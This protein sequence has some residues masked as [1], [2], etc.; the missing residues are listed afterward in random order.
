MGG[1]DAR[2]IEWMGG[3]KVTR[4]DKQTICVLCICR[5]SFAVIKLIQ[6][7]RLTTYIQGWISVDQMHV[8][9]NGRKDGK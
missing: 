9:S 6:K 5:L 3:R 4:M 2:T 8:R 1:S 7:V